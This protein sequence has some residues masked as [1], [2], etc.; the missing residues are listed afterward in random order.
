MLIVT[1]L[2]E[3]RGEE[4]KIKIYPL[5]ID[6]RDELNPTDEPI[7]PRM[8]VWAEEKLVLISSL[9]S[10]GLAPKLCYLG[11]HMR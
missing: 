11:R 10:D 8:R 4:R 9:G 1:L 6:G 3:W 7:R 5:K 2:E